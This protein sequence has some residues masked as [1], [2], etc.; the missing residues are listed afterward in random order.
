MTK[1]EAKIELPEPQY[2][3]SFKNWSQ[4]VL[5]FFDLGKLDLEIVV[6]I[7]P[8]MYIFW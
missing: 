5:T 1:Q 4:E 3:K 2:N 6:M 7:W 8:L